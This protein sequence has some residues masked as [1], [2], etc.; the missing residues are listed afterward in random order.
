MSILFCK[1]CLNIASVAFYFSVS[2]AYPRPQVHVIGGKQ[3]AEVVEMVNFYADLLGLDSH[4]SIVVSYQ[5][6]LPKGIA[7]YTMFKAYS[8]ENPI[9]Q[10]YIKIDIEQSSN[11]RLLTLAHEMVHVKQFVKGE[12][13]RCEN[14]VYRWNGK[15]YAHIHLIPYLQR[16]WEQEA[17]RKQFA[18]YKQF[19]QAKMRQEIK[20]THQ[21][22]KNTEK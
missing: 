6:D 22:A 9:M 15:Q 2:I 18:L 14:D 16:Q 19:R 3:K 10:V 1:L 8:G 20:H 13:I 21:L 12:L 5:S 11:A 7:G 17:L 4:I